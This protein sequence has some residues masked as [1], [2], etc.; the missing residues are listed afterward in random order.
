MQRGVSNLLAVMQLAI[1]EL[2]TAS[3][4][5]ASLTRYL[6]ALGRKATG[7]AQTVEVREF[8]RQSVPM[9]ERLLGD[10]ARI[11]VEGA[12]AGFAR[13]TSPPRRA[14][15]GHWLGLGEH[16]NQGYTARYTGPDA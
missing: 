4:R 6:P 12:S 7:D 3:A 11:E 5:G 1:D 9:F 8:V 2:T 10:S 14:L 16:T 13:V 15:I